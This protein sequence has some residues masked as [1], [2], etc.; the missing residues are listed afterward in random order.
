MIATVVARDEQLFHVFEL[1]CFF[2]GVE[3]KVGSMSAL[4]EHGFVCRK[5]MLRLFSPST[6]SPYSILF[7]DATAQASFF[8]WVSNQ[9]TR[10]GFVLL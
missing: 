5:I 8:P 1:G 2:V 9:A 7:A 10:F 3:R 6:L 4:S